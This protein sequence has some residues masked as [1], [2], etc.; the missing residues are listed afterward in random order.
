MKKTWIGRNQTHDLSPEERFWEKVAIGKEDK[1]WLWIGNG[2]RYGRFRYNGQD[3]KAHR[4]SYLLHYGDI[5][6]GYYVCHTCDNGLCVNPKH[7]FAGTQS[8]NMK[9]MYKKKRR[10]YNGKNYPNRKLSEKDVIHMIKDFLSGEKRK[11]LAIKY[12]ISLA[13]I[14]DILGGR[15]W[16]YLTKKYLL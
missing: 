1:C 12:N 13:T 3:W 11:D 4:Y 10:V 2:D 7:L 6:K 14:H 8:D 15:T 5:P 9:D 16:K